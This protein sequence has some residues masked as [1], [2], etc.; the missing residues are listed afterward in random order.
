ML[1]D[2]YHALSKREQQ[3]LI[4]AAPLVILLILW[5]LVIKP[6]IDTHNKL[7]RSIESNTVKL[8]WMQENAGRT[9]NSLNA[10]ANTH[11]PKNKS[12]LRQLMNK[13]LKSHQVSVERI[14]NING[15]DVSYRLNNPKFNNVLALI[16]SIEKQGIQM[17]QVQISKA[18]LVGIVNTRLVVAFKE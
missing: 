2:K 16:N 9:G 14:Q 17:V 12:Q 6:S 11:R 13:L 7:T 10:P 5:I 4:F 3:I 1:I 18:K 15:S 8:N